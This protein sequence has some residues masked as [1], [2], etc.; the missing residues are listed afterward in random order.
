MEQNRGIYTVIEA[1]RIILPRGQEHEGPLY[2]IIKGD[3]IASIQTDPPEVSN[4]MLLKTH[5][6]TPGFFDL[7]THGLG[8]Y[9]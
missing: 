5:L 6:L 1:R 8:H 3:V 7:H 4:A 2:I 9:E